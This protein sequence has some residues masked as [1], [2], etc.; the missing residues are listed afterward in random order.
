MVHVAGVTVHRAHASMQDMADIQSFAVQYGVDFVAASQ[1]R[2][3]HVCLRTWLTYRALPC[4]TGMDFV[5]ASQVRAMARKHER[6]HTTHVHTHVH[7]PPPRAGP[8]RQRH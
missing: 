3:M 4:S 8:V 2:G 1:V 7:A 6:V 5:A